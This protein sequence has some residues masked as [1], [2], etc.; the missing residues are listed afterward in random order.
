[1]AVTAIVIVTPEPKAGKFADYP[2]STVCL[3]TV[4]GV[5]T[6]A[7][8]MRALL[9]TSAVRTAL[10][11]GR[12]DLVGPF[13]YNAEVIHPLQLRRRSCSLGPTIFIEPNAPF[14]RGRHI[15]AFLS[16]AMLSREAVCR[17]ICSRR[18][19]EETFREPMGDGPAAGCL[20]YFASGRIA[21]ESTLARHHEVHCAPEAAF[22]IKTP[23]DLELARELAQ[24]KRRLRST[25]EP[26]CEALGLHV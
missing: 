20:A 10:L 14:L 18:H 26:Y 24:N 5:P 1:M 6:L 23:G 21:T 16:A 22:V 25:S 13:A 17:S 19:L 4:G 15:S 3:N 12:M 7:R 11:V 9:E 8:V 2:G